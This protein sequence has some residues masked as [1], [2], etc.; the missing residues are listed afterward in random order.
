MAESISRRG[1]RKY[2]FK[3]ELILNQ[4]KDI[5]IFTDQHRFYVLKKKAGLI[6][7]LQ[8]V[9]AQ[10]KGHHGA[11]DLL[12]FGARNHQIFLFLYKSHLYYGEASPTSNQ[13]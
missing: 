4:D 10:K 3:D 2:L 6:Q 7:C 8:I 11:G 5:V 13:A 1:F 9:A 12:D